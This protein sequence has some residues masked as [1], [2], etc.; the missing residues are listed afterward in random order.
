[1]FFFHQFTFFSNH[2]LC[3]KIGMRLWLQPKSRRV[4][5]THLIQSWTPHPGISSAMD[6]KRVTICNKSQ[7]PGGG[8][9]SKCLWASIFCGMSGTVDCVLCSATNNTKKHNYVV[10]N[11]FSSERCPSSYPCRICSLNR[12]ISTCLITDAYTAYRSLTW[13]CMEDIQWCRS[14]ECQLQA[15]ARPQAEY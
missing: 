6:F 12:R 13:R 15:T 8:G 7:R 11:V 4:C 5:R 3:R 1:M 2:H 9:G 14:V 10:N